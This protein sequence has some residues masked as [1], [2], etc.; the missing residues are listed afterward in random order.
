MINDGGFLR[1]ELL[2]ASSVSSCFLG[3]ALPLI[4]GMTSR[5]ISARRLPASVFL[6]NTRARSEIGGSRVGMIGVI[7]LSF[8]FLLKIV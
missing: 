1:L 6:R 4:I 5:A 3:L 8:F 2:C 7:G